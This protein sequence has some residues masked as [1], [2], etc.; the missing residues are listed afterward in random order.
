MDRFHYNLTGVDPPVMALFAGSDTRVTRN[1]TCAQ[2]ALK[3]E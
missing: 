1:L 2:S 3:D